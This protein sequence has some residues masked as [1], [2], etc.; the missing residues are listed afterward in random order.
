[1]GQGGS[2]GKVATIGKG[3]SN[4]IQ[5]G[6]SYNGSGVKRGNCVMDQFKPE[7]IKK[8]NPVGNT[9]PKKYNSMGKVMKIKFQESQLRLIAVVNSMGFYPSRRYACLW[10]KNSF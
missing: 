6:A 1:M 8:G 5:Q 4:I 2:N 3:G 10:D 9:Q 7:V